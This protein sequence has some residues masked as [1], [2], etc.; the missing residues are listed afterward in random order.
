MYAHHPA[1][2]HVMIARTRIQVGQE[3][4]NPID[5]VPVVELIS[6]RRN[7][8]PVPF[9]WDAGQHSAHDGFCDDQEGEKK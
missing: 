4:I 3:C 6:A 8:S 5:G 1:K 9:G 2:Q 7:T